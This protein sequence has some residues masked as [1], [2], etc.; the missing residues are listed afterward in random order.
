M[1]LCMMLCSACFMSEC[2]GIL[3]SEFALS[4]GCGQ[5]V[6]QGGDLGFQRRA[7]TAM[8]MSEAFQFRDAP[9]QALHHGAFASEGLLH[10]RTLTCH[11]LASLTPLSSFELGSI[12]DVSKTG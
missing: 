7:S 6:T 12:N 3:H 5:A 2:H 4:F 8:L 9:S 1:I 11:G 10:A